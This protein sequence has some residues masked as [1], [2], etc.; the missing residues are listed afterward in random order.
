M[1]CDFRT[2]VVAKVVGHVHIIDSAGASGK[3]IVGVI[4]W[5]WDMRA[6]CM[7]RAEQEQGASLVNAGPEAPTIRDSRSRQ[8]H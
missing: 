1:P 3:R 2:N 6:T 8:E 5:L 7:Q 4:D